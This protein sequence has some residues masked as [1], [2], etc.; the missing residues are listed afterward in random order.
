MGQPLFLK[1]Y[2][3]D[4]DIFLKWWFYNPI[5]KSQTHCEV[6]AETH[7]SFSPREG[8]GLPGS[9]QIGFFILIYYSEGDG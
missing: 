7:G 5:K 3:I 1:N 9:R 8:A 2:L 4:I 6:G